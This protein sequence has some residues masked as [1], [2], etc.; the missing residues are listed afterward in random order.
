MN[1]RFMSMLL[2]GMLFCV[3]VTGCGKGDAG[4]GET[5]R[6]ETRQEETRQ[7]ETGQDEPVQE[8]AQQKEYY[9]G[10]IERENLE[11]Y[12]YMDGSSS[13]SEEFMIY[14]YED[15]LIFA[16][17]YFDCGEELLETYPLTEEQADKVIEELNAVSKAAASSAENGTDQENADQEIAA[18]GHMR[19]GNLVID[20]TSYEAGRI[21][22]EGI[23]IEVKDA[24]YVEYS[25]DIADTFELEGFEG[26][27]ESDQWKR[28]SLSGGIWGFV[29]A[30]KEQ[31]EQQTGACFDGMVIGEPGAEDVTVRL[32]TEEDEWYTATVTY[33]GYVAGLVKE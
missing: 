31:A 23:G 27:Q 7:E 22:F 8:E 1:K 11:C 30:V 17:D 2:I 18:G 32:Y 20:G 12:Y 9:T 4:Q 25:A 24:A 21:D 6:E 33:Q 5:Q 10:T 14:R 26:L 29:R 15:Q 13:L 3:S 19:Y 28:H 16:A